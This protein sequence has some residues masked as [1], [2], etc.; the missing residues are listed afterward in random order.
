[1]DDLDNR[2]ESLPSLYRL[3]TAHAKSRLSKVVEEEDAELAIQ[4]VQFAYFKKV[5][6]RK[7]RKKGAESDDEEQ[8]DDAEP[9]EKGET[10][11]KRRRESSAE[12][13]PSKKKTRVEK[14]SQPSGASQVGAIFLL[15]VALYILSYLRTLPPPP[16]LPQSAR[17]D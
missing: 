8:V 4:L 11:S 2:C 15:V 6:D 3:S 17:Q 5:L 13:T 12:D 16:P 10:P 1:M 7:G 9:M 14:A